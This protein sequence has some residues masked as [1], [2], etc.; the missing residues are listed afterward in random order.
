MLV[1]TLRNPRSRGRERFIPEAPVARTGVFLTTTPTLFGVN[2]PYQPVI[3]LFGVDPFIDPYDTNQGVPIV[4]QTWWADDPAILTVN[5]ATGYSV[6][7]GVGTTTLRVVADGIH[8]SQSVTVQALTPVPDALAVLPTGPFTLNPG[9]T[10]QVSARPT[11]G[12]TFVAGIRNITWSIPGGA[13]IA[14][15]SADS[16]DDNHTATVTAV[17]AG[18]PVNITASYAPASLSATASLTVVA[19]SGTFPNLPSNLLLVNDTTFSVLPGTAVV[20][21]AWYRSGAPGRFT[22]DSLSA[23][24]FPAGPFGDLALAG[25][26]N[27]GD[28]DGQSSFALRLEWAL[29]TP[30]QKKLYVSVHF[31]HQSGW[32]DL[33]ANGHKYL[34][35]LDSNA[36]GG[37]STAHFVGFWGTSLLKPGFDTQFNSNPPPGAGWPST[38]YHQN[39]QATAG[40]WH[41]LEV[42]TES[43]DA[44][45]A[46]GLVRLYLDGVLKINE[47]DIPMASIPPRV[48][49]YRGMLWQLMINGSGGVAPQT[50]KAFIQR[51]YIAGLAT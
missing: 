2:D 30:V 24:G 45:S 33:M 27:A 16:D 37:A 28:P 44:G 49:G 34:W 36:G 48:P 14:T 9:Q 39:T 32:L 42:Y 13:G 21:G 6:S 8:L 51:I 47:T 23:G 40:S 7:A 12:G 11:N 25:Q 17:G 3:G 50:Q 20:K 26:V 1:A 18:G 35:W 31:L 4:S 15:V 5:P 46:N 29:G 43:G 41:Q 10:L 38:P 22:L 19:A